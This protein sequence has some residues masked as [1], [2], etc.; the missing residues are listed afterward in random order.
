MTPDE[1]DC[2]DENPDINPDAVEIDDGI[3]NDCDGFIDEYEVCIDDDDYTSIQDAIADANGAIVQLC[4]GIYEESVNVSGGTTTLVGGSSDASETV[5]QGEVMSPPGDIEPEEQADGS[6][7]YPAPAVISGTSPVVI[8]GGTGGKQNTLVLENLSVNGGSSDKG[9][10]IY[11]RNRT[12]VL[13]NVQ[14]SEGVATQG[15]A[16]FAQNCNIDIQ[17]SSFTEA[18]ATA[19]G[20]GAYLQN[21]TGTI[22]SS[23]FSENRGLEGGGMFVKNGDLNVTGNTINDNTA[24]AINETKSYG[25]KPSGGGGI[26]VQGNSSFTYNTIADNHAYRNGGGIHTYMSNPEFGHNIIADNSCWDDG[27]GYFSHKGSNWVHNNIFQGNSAADDAGGLRIY[28]G[29]T[30][31]I[32]DNQ[33]LNNSCNDA[34]GGLKLSHSK[35]IIRRNVFQENYAGN[36]GGGITLDN[37]TSN[38]EDCVF[39]EN[40]AHRGAGLHAWRNEGPITIERCEFIGNYAS[41]CGGGIQLDNNH[42]PITLHDLSLTENISGG[43]G[44]AFCSEVFILNDNLPEEQQTATQSNFKFTNSVLWNNVAG[45]DGAGIYVRLGTGTIENMVIHD[46]DAPDEGAGL[47]VKEDAFISVINTIITNNGSGTG[48]YLFEEVSTLSFSHSNIWGHDGGN[49]EGL[50]DPTGSNGNISENPMFTNPGDA[51]FSLMDSSPCVDSGQGQ[52]KDGSSADM[53]AYGGP[54]A[55]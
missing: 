19:Q 46:N 3:D 37:E 17:Q 6:S 24:T 11:C 40:V 28:V 53:G 8:D 27:G 22:A 16:L 34:G 55:P 25:G 20:G 31:T 9:G 50:A 38:V 41:Y 14:V 12:L 52:D 30:A 29:N 54:N 48:V 49:F 51:D 26:F 7:V 1:G 39:I 45:D 4:P 35:N 32:E 15:G 5:I 2:N 13:N 44:G 21:C 47:T 43:D 42:H 36:L 10:S 33:F 23:A 18:T